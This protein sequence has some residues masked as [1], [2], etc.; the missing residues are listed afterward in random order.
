MAIDTA[1]KESSEIARKRKASKNIKG[2]EDRPKRFKGRFSNFRGFL[3]RLYSEDK[4]NRL[5]K[6]RRINSINNSNRR[7]R[8]LREEAKDKNSKLK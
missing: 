3:K 6:A 8:S 2:V 7:K 4:A 5:V 1:K